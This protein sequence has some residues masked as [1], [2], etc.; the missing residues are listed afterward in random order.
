MAVNMGMAT[1]LMKAGCNGDKF[2]FYAN[3]VKLG[4]CTDESFASGNIGL[5]AGTHEDGGVQISFDNLKVLAIS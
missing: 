2:T 4:G 5:I 1:N 3:G